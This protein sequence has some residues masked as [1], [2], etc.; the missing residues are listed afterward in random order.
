MRK[1]A[2]NLI[3]EIEWTCGRDDGALREP[4]GDLISGEDLLALVRALARLAARRDLARLRAV[5]NVC[6]SGPSQIGGSCCP[7]EQEVALMPTTAE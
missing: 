1:S 3:V 4:T 6:N 7:V 2:Q 5:N